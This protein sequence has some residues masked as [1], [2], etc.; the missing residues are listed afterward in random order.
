MWS[1]IRNRHRVFLP[2]IMALG[3]LAL[4]WSVGIPEAQ[5]LVGTRLKIKGNWRETHV[6]A[7]SV[8][9]RAPEKDPQAGRIIGAIET[10]DLASK[11]LR[12]GPLRV[13]WDAETRLSTIS[14]NTLRPR[15]VIE[16]KGRLTAP[17][18]V[19]ATEVKPS[20]AKPGRLQLRGHVTAVDKLPRGAR[21]LMVLGVPVVI[22]QDISIDVSED[23]IGAAG[24]APRRL[25]D[26]RPDEQLTVPVFNRPLTIGGELSSELEYRRDIDLEE[27]AEDDLL[28]FEQRLEVELFYP[29]TPKL[30]LFLE[31]KVRY[32]ADLYAEDGMQDVVWG[33]DRGETWL[34][35]HH[36]FGTPFSLQAGRQSIEE[37]REWWWDADL[38]ALRLH[39]DQGRVRAEL[40]VAQEMATDT[41]ED[42][43]IDS[44]EAGIFRLL[45]HAVWEWA[46]KHD[47]AG[48]FLYQ[49]DHSERQREGDIVESDRRDAT[50]A[51]LVWFG[52]R[53]MG[54]LKTENLG[55]WSYWFDAAGVVGHEVVVG[56]D[57]TDDGRRVVDESEG[58]EQDVRGWAVDLG[59]SWKTPL[60]LRPTF[61][62]GYAVGSG[63]NDP[64]Q[65]PGK[66]FRQT[67]LQDNNSR[68]SG[69]NSFRYYGELLRP[70]LSNL[71]IW[72]VT[73]GI[74]IL[75]SSSVE[76]V[77]H[78]YRQVEPQD[79]L[80]D[81]RINAD[82][83]GEG[84]RIGQEWNLIVGIEEWKHWE[85]EWIGALFR[86]GSAYGDLSGELAYQVTLKVDYN[87]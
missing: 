11:S 1:A 67:G 85:I 27:E 81:V 3:V 29:L 50:D 47:L 25:D 13:S 44:E 38:D 16:V 22:P 36:L 42:S 54:S 46:S 18:Q 56:F 12:I 26:K 51:N 9:Q 5:S 73:L 76:L 24:Q 6:E 43:R 17:G 71:Q 57:R 82:P 41:S 75:N 45:G 7:T 52:V 20:S 28:R 58:I 8:E 65:G 19:A 68:F 35:W 83:E 39:Y 84:R 2:W 61:T 31:G 87:F 78:H 60:P 40:S 14:L 63:D 30:D 10:I 33:V 37:K 86:A 77:Y 4:S 15:D 79:R 69:V 21:R 72:T 80:R 64:D 34:L 53:A 70:E 59:V 48:F 74:P 49:H 62:L 55:E 32:R 23:M 66:A